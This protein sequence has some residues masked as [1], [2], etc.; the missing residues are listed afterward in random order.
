MAPYEMLHM[1]SAWMMLLGGGLVA[2]VIVLARASRRHAL[3][4]KRRSEEQLEA[5]TH[6]F[7]GGV[8]EQNRPVPVLIWI[9][10]VGYFVWAAAYVI[11]T[12]GTG[13]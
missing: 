2:L 6:E 11:F 10:T 8:R 9:V 12:A 13:V 3:S 5:E 4:L 7:P 1:E